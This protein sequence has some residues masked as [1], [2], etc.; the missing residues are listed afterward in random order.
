MMVKNMFV[1][2]CSIAT[3]WMV[4]CRGNNNN[5]SN[6]LPSKTVQTEQR[7]D[8]IIAEQKILPLTQRWQAGQ[9]VSQAEID[10]TGIENCFAV[11]Q[12]SDTVFARMR[13]KSW[14][15]N[16]PVKISELRYLRLLHANADGKPQMGELIVNAQIADCVAN[17]FR[18]LY[19]SCYRIERMLLIDNYNADDE[20]SMRDNNTSS[21][22]YRCVPGTKTISRHSYGLAID[23]NP[24]YNP[25]I[26]SDKNGKTLISPDNALEYAFGRDTADIPYKITYDDLAYRLFKKAG[27]TWGGS[28]GRM[29]D[30]QHFEM[31]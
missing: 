20:L 22:N 25:Y 4:S 28:W 5:T 15:E 16:C 1:L 13:G 27:F 3:L 23:L 11:E 7:F 26:R 10:A 6:S 30:Y 12:I 21:F 17:I 24:R 18:Q 9:E 2:L 31:R 29:K 19:D 8:T 14:P